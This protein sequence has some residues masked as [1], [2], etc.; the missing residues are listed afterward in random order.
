MKVSILLFNGPPGSGKDTAVRF[1]IDE[2]RDYSAHVVR[3]SDPLKD[4]ICSWL[5]IRRGSPQEQ[6]LER[7]KDE[8]NIYLGGLSYRQAQIA[9]SEMH[10]KPTYGAEIFGTW[11]AARI[12][13]IVELNAAALVQKPQTFFVPDS[14]FES[15][16][17][18]LRQCFPD[19]DIGIMQVHR[20]DYDFTNDSRSYIEPLNT[21]IVRVDNTTLDQYKQN[22]MKAY[23][24]WRKFCDPQRG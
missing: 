19:A 15:E 13:R 6:E 24:T 11:L 22:V 17:N 14:G 18:S 3:F 21:P 23:D 1:L 8:P 9:L 20:R 4:S 2:N 12:R 7:Y 5:G 10:I 16:F